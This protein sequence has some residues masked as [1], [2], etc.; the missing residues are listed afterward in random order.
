MI[1]TL[2][3]WNSVWTIYIRP[4]DQDHVD[5]GTMAGRHLATRAACTGHTVL[6]KPLAEYFEIMTKKASDNILLVT[7]EELKDYE[8]HGPIS[9]YYM[10]ISQRA[11]CAAAR[12]SIIE[13]GRKERKKQ[14]EAAAA[15]AGTST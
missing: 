4:K 14:E 12:S 1:K 9:W 8:K 11:F 10:Q 13:I 6:L 15:A 5:L 7:E 3:K 2:E